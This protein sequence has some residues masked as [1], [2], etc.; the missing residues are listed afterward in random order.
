MLGRVSVSIRLLFTVEPYACSCTKKQ[1]QCS[2]N[3]QVKQ[4][5]R[6]P[7]KFEIGDDDAAADDDDCED[8]AAENRTKIMSIFIFS[9]LCK[10]CNALSSTVGTDS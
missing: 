2:N 9:E 10:K 7:R 1:I 8:K 4:R 3:T 5:V 6:Q